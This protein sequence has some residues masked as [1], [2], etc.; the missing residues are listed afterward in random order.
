MSGL[1][2]QGKKGFQSSW[3]SQ[4]LDT[5]HV[6]YGH[7][8]VSWLCGRLKKSKASVTIKAYRLGLTKP[9]EIDLF[10]SNRRD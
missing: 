7:V 1:T 2:F 3:S 8:S 6:Y 9:R 5:L 10:E 4:D